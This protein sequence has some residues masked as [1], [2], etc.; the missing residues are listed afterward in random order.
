M[1]S[2][3]RL[4][5]VRITLSGQ[6]LLSIDHMIEPGSLLTVMGPSGSGKSTLLSFIAGF[7][8]APFTAEGQVLLKLLAVACICLLQQGL[9]Q[10]LEFAVPPPHFP[11]FTVA[12]LR[13]NLILCESSGRVIDDAS[14]IDPDGQEFH[15][16]L[17]SIGDGWSGQGH[18]GLLQKAGA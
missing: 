10:G 17:L 15:G 16:E 12:A 13:D 6:T 3:L 4:K 7:L 5:N 2:G 18:L 8:T 1:T 11:F 9:V 14:V